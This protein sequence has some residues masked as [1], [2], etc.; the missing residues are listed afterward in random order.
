MRW[1]DKAH[2]FP[3]VSVFVCF[4]LVVLL[5][6]SLTLFFFFLY[7]LAFFFIFLCFFSWFL[8]CWLDQ[9]PVVRESKN[10]F[11]EVLK[12]IQKSLWFLHFFLPNSLCFVLFCSPLPLF[13]QG[14]THGYAWWV[15]F[16]SH[17]DKDKHGLKCF[18]GIKKLTVLPLLDCW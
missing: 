7:F 14:W 9:Q 15:C 11:A 4:S 8:F 16:I 1:L 13:L 5:S 3:F 10:F 17:E 12:E 6:S 18:V 2:L